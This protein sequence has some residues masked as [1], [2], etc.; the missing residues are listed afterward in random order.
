MGM[1]LM[2]VMMNVVMSEDVAAA[3]QPVTAGPYLDSFTIQDSCQFNLCGPEY[4]QEFLQGSVPKVGS[5]SGDCNLLAIN[6][7]S[8]KFI[9]DWLWS[10]CASM[11]HS[12]FDFQKYRHYKSRFQCMEQCHS[13]YQSVSPHH[14]LARYCA[15]VSCSSL[16][17]KTYQIDCYSGCTSH[18]STNVSGTDW[19]DWG[20]ALAGH[21]SGHNAKL[22]C[23]DQQLWKN[24]VKSYGL[25][26]SDS[27][28]K[29]CH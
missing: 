1:I 10:N 27:V 15:K 19:R 2:I 7:V 3:S 18:V 26:D 22:E 20:L 29:S 17:S 28:T 21:C 23:A 13:S 16:D 25:T 14:N 8:N 11:C 24:I 12:K 5:C 4:S 9:R 6:L